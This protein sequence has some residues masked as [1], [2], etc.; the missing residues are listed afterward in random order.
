MRPICLQTALGG[1]GVWDKGWGRCPVNLMLMDEPSEDHEHRI[2]AL[3][4]V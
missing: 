2:S 4:A 3:V 1:G